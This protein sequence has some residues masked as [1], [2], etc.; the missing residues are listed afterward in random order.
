MSLP[1]GLY[2]ALVSEALADALQRLE[3]WGVETRGLDADTSAQILARHLHG[4][5]LKALE[6]QPSETRLE[7]Q[8]AL[9]NDLVRWLAE[10]GPKAGIDEGDALGDPASLLLS[11][12]HPGEARLGTGA[13][14]R[15]LLPLRQSALL[16]N[17]PR[18]VRVGH[19]IQRELP[20][21]DRVDVLVAF[22]KDSG[23]RVILPALRQFLT[24]RPGALRVL[25]TTYTGA[26]ELEAIEKLIELGADVRV[27][28][29]HRRTRLH[30]KAWLFHRASEF[31]TALVGSSNLSRA[32]LL[33]GCEWNVRLTEVDNRPLLSQFRTTFDQYWADE[34]FEP[35]DRA[36]F[37]DSSE[38][39]DPAR[40]AIAR[41][42]KPRPYRH[43]QQV[44]DALDEERRHGHWRNLVVS[45][46]GTGK[47]IVAAL[48]Y[49]RLHRAWG[50]ATLLFVAHREQILTQSLGAFRAAMGDGH[51]GE[52]LV[53]ASKPI[54]G[55]HVFASVQ[56]LHAKRLEKL[57]PDAFDVVI[58]D[59]F[60]HAAAR[61]YT[62]LLSKLTPRV[63]LGLTATPERTDGK[64][65]LGWFDDRV[66]AEL[67]LWDALDL[68][69]LSPFQY[70]GL[71]D[72]TDLSR[73]DFRAGR[74]DTTALERIYT[75]DDARA[76]SVL[77]ATVE[78]VRDPRAMRALGFCVSVRHAEFMAAFFSARGIPAKAVSFETSGADLVDAVQDLRT[79]AVNV[80]FTVDKFNE[81][82]DLPMVD[83]VLFLRPTESATVFLQQLGRGLRLDEG[84]ACLTVLDFIG[85]SHEKFRFDRRFQALAGGTRAD[86]LAA[87]EEGFPYLPGGCDIQLDREAQDVVVRN[88]RESLR[89]G[90]SG[91]AHDLAQTGDVGLRAF[92]DRADIDLAQLYKGGRSYTALL[93]QAGLRPGP[94][95]DGAPARALERLL[96]V[97]D[98]RR[99]DTWR[100]WLRAPE[101]PRADPN[102]PL[103]LML[104]AAAGFVRRS[105]ADL[106]DAFA[107][108]WGQPDLRREYLALF[109]LL[110][111]QLR[112]PTHPMDD[113][114][115]QV[116]ATY[117]R[118][119]VSAGL[120]QLRKGKLLR[121]QG[122]VYKD[123]ASRS[124]ILFVTLEKTEKEFTP[125]TLYNDYPITPTRFH[126]ESQ[127][128]TRS[129]S[130]TGRRYQGHVAMGWRVLLFVRHHKTTRG[131]TSPYLFLGP[132]TYAEHQSDKPMQ[133][134]WQLERAMPPSFWSDVKVAAG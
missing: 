90:W 102:D 37:L 58:V 95:P 2:E 130:K 57:A 10:R 44:L 45:A 128:K 63:L 26:T 17:G 30:A 92:L 24:R 11:L 116:H 48:D 41:A 121:T 93:H 36:R 78:K 28:Y 112:R 81:G 101:P 51:F 42:V 103:Q 9:A 91:L 77:R 115:F 114:P 5:L 86:V 133:I 106:A 68:G 120:R 67:R 60:H 110:E 72:G 100:S 15:P 47:T 25:T 134:I 8:L 54:H 126:W 1:P 124:D 4:L 43:Q 70:F 117:A 122:G 113:L 22:L 6:T 14:P 38:R 118:D 129:D 125:T 56:S 83:T 132:V 109:D 20:S 119:E 18:D 29:D 61:T 131:V 27:S 105:V 32:A 74:Y 39:R 108:L 3:G 35:Y 75:A 55:T 127:A 31:S 82:V 16:A 40:D 49:A 13:L 79:G 52:L 76:A 84:K 99:L 65:V 88:I 53:G 71:H 64:S 98:E 97:D 66:A 111:D 94:P 73:V 80:L 104:F 23:L 62:D 107:E 19:M 12:R 87:V 59:E 96:H 50:G 21:A 69:L 7:D 89:T 85:T 46:T 34:V 33:D 123:D